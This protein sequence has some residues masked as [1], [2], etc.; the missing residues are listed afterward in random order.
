MSS[1]VY[2]RFLLSKSSQ[3]INFTLGQFTCGDKRCTESEGLRSWEA[4]SVI[5][6]MSQKTVKPTCILSRPH[7]QRTL[8]I[9]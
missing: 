4:S 1:S 3:T 6:L 2:R 7:V 8:S 9:K 5:L